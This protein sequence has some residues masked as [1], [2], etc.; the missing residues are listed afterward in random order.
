MVFGCLYDNPDRGSYSSQLFLFN[1]IT[2]WDINLS[3]CQHSPSAGVWRGFVIVKH[4]LTVTPVASVVLS[5]M[6]LSL[7]P[8][9]RFVGALTR[10][11]RVFFDVLLNEATPISS[12]LHGWDCGTPLQKRREKKQLL[13]EPIFIQGKSSERRGPHLSWCKTVFASLL[14]FLGGEMSG[15][16]ALWRPWLRGSGAALKYR[17]PELPVPK[18]LI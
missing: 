4:R 11:C 12:L 5:D 7:D 3:L 18:S 17:K 6:P 13:S 16:R 8:C 1:H 9:R 15:L 10:C 2:D 14:Q